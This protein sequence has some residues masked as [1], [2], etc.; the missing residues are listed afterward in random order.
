MLKVISDQFEAF[1]ALCVYKFESYLG[2][3][4]HIVFLMVWGLACT[5]FAALGRSL[6][7]LLNAFSCCSARKKTKHLLLCQ[8]KWLRL[9]HSLPVFYLVPLFLYK[10]N[11]CM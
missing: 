9:Q 11:L 2:V 8:M 4:G 7:E 10:Y 1:C 6:V 3:L 5:K